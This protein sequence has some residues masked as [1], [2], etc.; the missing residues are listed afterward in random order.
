M[1]RMAVGLIVL[2]SEHQ[3]ARTARCVPYEPRTDLI[4]VP[5]MQLVLEQDFCLIGLPNLHLQLG[6]L[7]LE[8]NLQGI[9]LFPSLLP[10]H[11]EQRLEV[12]GCG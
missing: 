4:P 7:S 2:S 11:Q 12:L 1:A 6:R 9:V 3:H 5:Q 8:G 10:C